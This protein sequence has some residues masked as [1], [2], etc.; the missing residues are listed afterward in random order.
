MRIP[1]AHL[2]GTNGLELFDQ[3]CDVSRAVENAIEKLQDAWPKARDYY[4][5][6]DKAWGECMDEWTAR[7]GKLVEV[8]EELDEILEGITKQLEKQGVDPWAPR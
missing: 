2:N 1:T 3:I 8:K 7:M 6:K 5:Q 4:T